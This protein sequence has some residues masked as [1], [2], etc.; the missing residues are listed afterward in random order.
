M[1]KHLSG[2]GAGICA[3][4]PVPRSGASAAG[5]SLSDPPMKTAVETYEFENAIPRIFLCGR[6]DADKADRGIAYP[7]AHF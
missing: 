1:R 4:K 3:T 7:V 2:S 5:S 6:R